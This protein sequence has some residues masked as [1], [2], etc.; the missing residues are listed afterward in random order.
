MPADLDRR[1][2]I[3]DSTPVSP[4]LAREV[5]IAALSTRVHQLTII[6]RETRQRLAE[7]ERIADGYARQSASTAWRLGASIDRIAGRIAPKGSRRRRAIR[8]AW[9]FFQ[10]GRAESESRDPQAANAYDGEVIEEPSVTP[11]RPHLRIPSWKPSDTP[12]QACVVILDHEVP[13]PD[14]DAGSLRMTEIIK[15]IRNRGHHVTFIPDVATTP[16][17]YIEDLEQLGVVVV[18]PPTGN[19]AERYL[20]EHGRA[21]DLVIL[22]REGVATHHLDTVRRLAP[23]ARVVFD[24]VDLH[25]LRERRAAS[26]AED[27]EQVWASRRRK[28]R[29]LSLVRRCDVTLVVSP[30]EQRILRRQCPGSDIRVL[31]TIVDVPSDPP[32]GRSGRDGILFIGGFRHAPN[33][34]AVHYFVAQILP[35]ILKRAPSTVFRVVGSHAPEEFEAFQDEHVEILGYVPDLAPVLDRA[36]ISVAPLRFGAGVKGKVNVSMAHGVPTVI[37]PLAA[38][39]MHLIHRHDTMIADSPEAFAAAVVELAESPDLWTTLAR[40]GRSSVREHF[41]IEAVR[42][43]IDDLLTPS[44]IR[45]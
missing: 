6:L 27:R 41:S 17:R 30:F 37:S 28:L 40:N 13:T 38:E 2:L 35:L 23:R 22:S 33:I 26:I 25:Y 45:R 8:A 7:V 14:L 34:D 43:Q 36:L 29:E 11:S 5:R 20:E 32:P 16:D 24:T 31:P 3:A 10:S 1:G 39:G 12:D 15:A 19:T 21:I 4:D 42:H 44:G 9:S 18:W